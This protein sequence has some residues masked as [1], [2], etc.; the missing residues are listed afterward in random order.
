MHEIHTEF[1]EFNKKVAE[2]AA[3]IQKIFEELGV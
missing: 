3:K 1:A 2:L